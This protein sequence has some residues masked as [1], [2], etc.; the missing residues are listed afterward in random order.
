MGVGH[1]R[2]AGE[3]I[4][5]LCCSRASAGP[6]AASR[7]RPAKSRPVDL[8]PIDDDQAVGLRAAY[9]KYL[10]GIPSPGR[11]MRPRFPTVGDR[12]QPAPCRPPRASGR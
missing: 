5:H 3:G 7:D 8:A 9:D 4:G 12:R 11:Q 2:T 10:L 1:A 6:R